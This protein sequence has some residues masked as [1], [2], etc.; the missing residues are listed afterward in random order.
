V[1][2]SSR[3]LNAIMVVDLGKEQAVWARTGSWHGQHDPHLLGNG[4]ILFFDN[5][6]PKRRSRI[7]ELDPT[8]GEEIIIYEGDAN[9]RFYTRYCGTTYR[10]P[11]GNTLITES[12]S[13]RVFEIDPAGEIVW[14]FYNPERA[15]TDKAFIAATPDLQ[16][17]PAS[18]VRWLN[19]P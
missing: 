14:E 16:R 11:N 3:L 2:A 4:R 13:G 12:D 18:F 15:G 19:R 5:G 9:R 6:E 7:L 17:I 8:T 1:L 10:L